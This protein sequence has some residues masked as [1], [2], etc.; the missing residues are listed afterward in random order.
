MYTETN[1][2]TKKELKEAHARGE[3]IRVCY[4]GIKGSVRTGKVCLEGPHYPK[5]HSWYAEVEIADMVIV[6]GSKIK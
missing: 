1:F 4:P 2:K 6:P 5:A 3:E